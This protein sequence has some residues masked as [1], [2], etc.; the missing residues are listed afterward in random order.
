MPRECGQNFP[1]VRIRLGLKL[2]ELNPCLGFFLGLLGGESM[3]MLRLRGDCC[4][5]T[6][7]LL[8]EGDPY[9]FSA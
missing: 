2:G 4:C 6:Q 8:H 9:N 5:E 3:Q 7:S 1:C